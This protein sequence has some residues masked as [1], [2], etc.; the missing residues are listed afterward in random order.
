MSVHQAAL[1]IGVMTSGFI[2]GAIAE[3]WGWRSVF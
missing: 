3:H 2:G 1:Y